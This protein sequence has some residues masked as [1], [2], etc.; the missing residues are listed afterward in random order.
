M[1]GISLLFFSLLL[2][3]S[4]CSNQ[5]ADSSGSDFSGGPLT[6]IVPTAAGG[7][8]DIVTRSL[9]SMME[10]EMDRGIG[11]EN[12]PG[13]SN[14]IGMIE[15]ANADPNGKTVTMVV[16]ELAM[17]NDLGLADISPD[18]YKPVAMV[19]LDPAAITVPA[20]APYDTLEEFIAYAKEH[21][22]EIK[23]GNSG[24]GSIWHIASEAMG[25]ETNTSY[26]NVPYEGAGPAVTALAG[27]HVDAVTVSAAEVLPQVESGEF[28]TLA[29]MSEERVEA[30]PDVPTF[31]EEGYDLGTVGT[32]RGLCVPVDT[33]EQTVDKLEKSILETAD[34]K[35][36]EE[37][38]NDGGYGLEIKDSEEFQAFLNEQS[39]FFDEMLTELDMKQEQ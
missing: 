37:F 15:G 10:E 6:F 22:D 12:I 26:T 33:P 34:S 21:P 27:G 25:S 23:I 14:A 35:E 2:L 9:G 8:T 32:W 29:V 39:E 3:L 1:K 24:T 17:L 13:G 30:M 7:G 36:F 28:K 18:D 5:N 11:V 4:S 19:N 20:D 31:E 16:A 38:M